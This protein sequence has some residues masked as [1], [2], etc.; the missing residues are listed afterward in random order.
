MKIGFTGT[1]KGMT[2]IQRI[3]LRV[4]LES[5]IKNIKPAKLEFHHGDCVGADSEAHDIAKSLGIF[6]VV[7]PP[8]DPKHRAHKEGDIIFQPQEYLDRNKDIVDACD[9]MIAM[10]KTF[11]EVVRSGTWSTVR[12]AKLV[13][14]PV[15]VFL[16]NGEGVPE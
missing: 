7:H 16:P 15:I 3:M 9:S 2:E 6:V 1:R 4:F 13:G 14:K 12:Y 11:H 8:T 5:V 10:S